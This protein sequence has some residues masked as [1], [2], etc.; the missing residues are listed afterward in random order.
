MRGEVADYSMSVKHRYS[1]IRPAEGGR[2]GST[3]GYVGRR[4]PRRRSAAEEEKCTCWVVM[5]GDEAQPMNRDTADLE[6]VPDPACPVHGRK[7]Y[8]ILDRDY[9]GE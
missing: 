9:W 8:P 2:R 7:R 5:R 4:P 6:L 1:R 3:K